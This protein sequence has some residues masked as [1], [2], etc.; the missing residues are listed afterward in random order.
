MS[1]VG[2]M[3]KARLDGGE[4]LVQSHHMVHRRARSPNDITHSLT[5]SLG[6]K[7]TRAVGTKSVT[8]FVASSNWM[9]YAPVGFLTS[10]DVTDILAFPP[11]VYSLGLELLS[12]L[13][14]LIS[15]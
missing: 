10:H 11:T 5:H 15:S 9:F 2:H 8:V 13:Q 12:R 4:E 3:Q 6:Q 14:Q 1:L 7:H